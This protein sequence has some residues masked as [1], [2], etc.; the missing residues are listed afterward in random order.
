[1]STLRAL[2]ALG[3]SRAMTPIAPS[4][5]IATSLVTVPR[6][7]CLAPQAAFQIRAPSASAGHAEKKT[8]S[9]DQCSSDRACPR[10]RRSRR[11]GPALPCRRHRLGRNGHRPRHPVH[12]DAGAGTCRHLDPPAADG[13]CRPRHRLW[14]PRQGPRGRHAH[15]D[16]RGHRGR[17]DRH[18]HRPG[19]DGHRPR[20]RRRHRRHRQARASPPT[21]ISLPWNTASTSS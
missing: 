14:R 20:D 16:V 2:I 3:R 13:P 21:T 6:L 19:A 11:N 5:P 8:A 7:P 10:P 12:A 4:R 18:H 15:E 17:Q 1:M 9:H